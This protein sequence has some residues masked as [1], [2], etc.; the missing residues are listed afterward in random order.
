MGRL[1]LSPHPLTNHSTYCP[2]AKWTTT[3]LNAHKLS[4]TIR[5]ACY[6]VCWQYKC[7]LGLVSFITSAQKSIMQHVTVIIWMINGR[8]SSVCQVCLF[9]IVFTYN[10]ICKCKGNEF[11]L[12]IQAEIYVLDSFNFLCF[13]LMADLMVLVLN[14]TEIYWTFYQQNQ[15][16]FC[17]GLYF[18]NCLISA[19]L[20]PKCITL[21]FLVLVAI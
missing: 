1:I 16:P 21:Y 2:I 14:K 13:V 7:F 8:L 15:K 19:I 3:V 17:H 20:I 18:H 9:V 4:C 5:I 12:H 11:S 10:T 6:V